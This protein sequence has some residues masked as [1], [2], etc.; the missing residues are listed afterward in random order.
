MSVTL[1]EY[2]L[3][4]QSIGY[5]LLV[6]Q[7]MPLGLEL[8]CNTIQYT[9][10]EE[11]EKERRRKEEGRKERKREGERNEAGHLDLM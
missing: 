9:F 3:A 4:F 5:A 11:G 6:L 1:I 10:V 8:I 2:I 7:F